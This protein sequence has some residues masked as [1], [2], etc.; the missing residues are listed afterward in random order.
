MAFRV[1][2]LSIAGILKLS[3]KPQLLKMEGI[4][5]SFQVSWETQSGFLL[6]RK[7]LATLDLAFSIIQ[8]AGRAS[9]VN[10]AI[11][12]VITYHEILN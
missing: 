7:A 3:F 10:Y 8:A 1:K 2:G 11:L 12:V 5:C 6:G 9:R 4:P